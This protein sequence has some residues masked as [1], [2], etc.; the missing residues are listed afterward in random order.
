MTRREILH[1]YRR[2][3]AITTDHHRAALRFL[4]AD[5]MLDQ[6][7][8]LGMR[9]GPSLVVDDVK[10]LSVLY[11][12]ALY[13]ARAGRSR[14]IDRYARATPLPVGS[15]EAL[16][17]EALRLARFSL[18]RVE[19]R[20]DVTGL[21]VSDLRNGSALWLIDE[22]MQA[23]VANGW[24][25]A[26]RILQPDCFAMTNGLIVPVQQQTIDKLVTGG[27]VSCRS[28]QAGAADESRFAAEVY[29]DALDNRLLDRV[30]FK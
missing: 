20:H 9:A 24:V 17:L 14:A 5:T 19:R 26:A 2:L 18:W 10:E 27:Q 29:R 13:T 23:S 22:G 21:M 30:A 25:F 16:T 3:R 11:E 4:A 6:A 12:F 8:R 28:D 15:D 7:R 1:R